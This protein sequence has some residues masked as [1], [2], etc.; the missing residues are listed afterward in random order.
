VNVDAAHRQ[1]V[2]EPA[3][4]SSTGRTPPCPELASIRPGAPPAP[5]KV[6]LPVLPV[7]TTVVALLAEVPA[8][9]ESS[10][11][12]EVEAAGGRAPTAEAAPY[13]DRIQNE[14]LPKYRP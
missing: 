5:D 14:L 3:P 12:R 6:E 4:P 9:L 11:G 2:D 7:P 10:R 1:L 13:A 8:A